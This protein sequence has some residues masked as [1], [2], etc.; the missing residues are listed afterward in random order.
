MRALHREHRVAVGDV[1]H[2]D[3]EAATPAT[4]PIE[5]GPMVGG[6]GDDQPAVVA[7][8]V[9]EE[10]VEDP[11]AL[12]AQARVLGAADID[13][14]DVVGEHPLQ[15]GERPGPLDL[16]LPHVGNVEHPGVGANRR[17]LLADPLILNGHLPA[18]EVH[19]L[20]PLLEMLLI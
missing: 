12:V 8:P 11:P 10:I 2:G 9:G 17:V 18:G 20:R 19:Q 16:D 7:E 4:E 5:V 13:G 15:E 3:V 1:A 14:A 6:V